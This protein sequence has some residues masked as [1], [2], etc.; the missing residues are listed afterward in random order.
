MRKYR[1]ITP[2]EIHKL[3]YD[4]CIAGCEIEGGHNKCNN[5][6][7]CEMCRDGIKKIEKIKG[8]EFA[9]SRTIGEVFQLMIE[10]ETAHP[11][12]TKYQII[13]A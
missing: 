7:L 2:N 11:K 10:Y 3:K 8:T 5:K 6:S 9:N 4:K 1:D 12:L 13:N